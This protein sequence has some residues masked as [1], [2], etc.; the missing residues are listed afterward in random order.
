V[1]LA[2]QRIHNDICLA[3][4]VMHVELVFFD[5]L[6][7]SSLSHVQI[8]LGKVVLQAFVVCIDVNHI[9]NQTVSLRS[10]WG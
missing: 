6:E 9:P 7:P 10:C 5:E 8:W 3:Q 2:I 1:S 4:V